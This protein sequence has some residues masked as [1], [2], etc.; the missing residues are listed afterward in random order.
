VRLYTLD[1]GPFYYQ[2]L[3]FSYYELPDLKVR[4]VAKWKDLR[5]SSAFLLRKGDLIFNQNLQLPP[6]LENLPL[7]RVYTGFP[8]WI[9]QFNVN[10]WQARTPM[11][12]VFRMER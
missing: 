9:L 12:A 5:D 6:E 8:N 10:N 11:W 4:P 2:N 3:R 7:R 1:K